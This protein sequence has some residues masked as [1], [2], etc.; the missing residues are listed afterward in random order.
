MKILDGKKVQEEIF[1]NQKDKFK[2]LGRK[3][4]LVIVSVGEN[5]ESEIYIKHKIKYGEALG[6][7]VRRLQL[8]M[9]ISFVDLKEKIEGLNRDSDVSGIIIQLPA[10]NF[11]AEDLVALVHPKKDVDGFN[12]ESSVKPATA[13]GVE[14]LLDFYNITI[15]NKKTVVLGD[16][17]IVGTPLAKFLKDAGAEVK[18]LNRESEN[19]KRETK[20]ADI[21]VFATGAINFFNCDYLGDN[22]PTVIDVGISRGKNG[23]VC[24]DTD[25]G[26]CLEKIG[27][28]TPVPGGVGP[29]TVWALFE[30]LYSLVSS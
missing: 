7:E 5:F 27:A 17:L 16:S 12:K 29:M 11:V 24:G 26:S 8:P 13:R 1:L 21:L 28:L 10:G 3:A 6:V 4:V 15:E 22:L 30:N 23:K 18:V 14:K 19:I 2:A 20:G 9:G 25:F